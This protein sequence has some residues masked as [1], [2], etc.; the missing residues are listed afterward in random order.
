[1]VQATETPFRTDAVRIRSDQIHRDARMHDIY[2]EY[3]SG[4][5]A[6]ADHMNL[7]NDSAPNGN[8]SLVSRWDQQNP[9][10]KYRAVQEFLQTAA[11]SGD[12]DWDGDVDFDDFFAFADAFNS[13]AER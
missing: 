9:F 2:S 13:T 4:W 5:F 1:M 6:I 8:F 11:V 7:F 12:G 10:P 3:L